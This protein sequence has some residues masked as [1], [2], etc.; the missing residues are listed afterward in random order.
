MTPR[1]LRLALLAATCLLAAPCLL[2]TT[3]TAR[4][5]DVVI[6]SPLSLTGLYA[7]VGTDVQRGMQVAAEEVNASGEL[8]AGRQ[9]KIR[10]ED[11]AGDRNQAITLMS[12]FAG[13]DDVLVVAGPSAT[14]TSVAASAVANDRKIPMMAVSNSGV[15][16]AAGPWSFHMSVTNA[17]LVEATARYITD[18]LKAK[19]VMSVHGRDTEAAVEY[20][21]LLDAQLQGKVTLPPPESALM[22][23]T[24][25]SAVATKIAAVQPDVVVIAMA[26][27]NAASLIAQCREAGVDDT[28][29][30]F[31]NTATASPSFLRIGGAAVEGS[32]MVSDAYVQGRTDPVVTRF[33]SGYQAMFHSPPTQWAA[34][35]YTLVHVLT[36][37]IADIHGPLTRD[38]VRDGITHVHDLDT[39]LGT[40]KYS[41]GPDREPRYQPLI[42][43]V[44]NGAFELAP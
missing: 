11:D 15:V 22:A 10:F 35:G 8:G 44:H 24:N 4:A 27:A 39:V 12:R 16:S 13:Q 23:E 42:L 32:L 28:T 36:G 3:A 33:V 40:G 14:I 37:V 2:A 20:V 19:T 29:R 1:T 26:D 30:F 41:I 9:L 43:T 7:F 18:K 31:G 25:F 5:E 38:A 17:L 34:V 6:G 21:R